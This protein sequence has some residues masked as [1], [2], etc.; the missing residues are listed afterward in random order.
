MRAGSSA[1]ADDSTTGR[2]VSRARSKRASYGP[3]RSK[4]AY[5]YLALPLSF[6]AV[7]MLLPWI[8][9]VFLSFYR[10][11]GIGVATPVGLHNYA[12]V[13]SNP[14]LRTAI[15]H[16]F[17][18]MLFFCVLPIVIALFMT[19]LITGSRQPRWSVIRAIL[20]VPQVLPPVAIGV[21]WQ[22]MY[23]TD[24]FIN[25][26]LHW[27]GLGSLAKPWLASF[28]WAFFAVGFVGVWVTTGLCLAFFVSG[29]QKVSTELYE[30]VQIDGGGRARQFLSVTLPHLRGEI[31]IAATVTAISALSAFDI[32]YV[33][34]GGGPGTTTIVPGV[35]V[36]QLGFTTFQVGQA[37]ALAVVLSV[38]VL[39]VVS[40]FRFIGRERS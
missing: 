9:T 4:A 11:D 37:S 20:F 3:R 23:G 5:A 30:A 25:Q 7:F 29:A 31:V 8:Q 13:L 26:A 40:A 36:Y 19:A 17:E 39:V 24:G 18:L 22:W 12:Q 27:V 16:S 6:Y 35:L 33:M 38:L 34:T 21:M 14:Q 32:V 2:S 1:A 28:T 10:W 15:V